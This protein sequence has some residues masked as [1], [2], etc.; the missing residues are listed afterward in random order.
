[1]EL[2]AWFENTEQIDLQECLLVMELR[3]K[4]DKQLAWRAEKCSDYFDENTQ[5]K[6]IFLPFRYESVLKND[7]QIHNKKLII[8]LWNKNQQVLFE[9]IKYSLSIE[10]DNNFIYGLTQKNR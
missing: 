5:Q 6:M 3:D 8:Y 4:H 7:A 1:M 2:R 10:N 9:N